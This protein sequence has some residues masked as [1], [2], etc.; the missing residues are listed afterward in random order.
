MI[1]CHITIVDHLTIFIS[2]PV[3]FLNLT[4]YFDTIALII[5]LSNQLTQSFPFLVYH[6]LGSRCSQP[7]HKTHFSW[8]R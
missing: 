3:I 5:L 8:S 1:S 4:N 7:L 2:L 6:V